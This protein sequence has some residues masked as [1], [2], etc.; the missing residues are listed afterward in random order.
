MRD[1][2]RTNNIL[3]GSIFILLGELCFVTM[4]SLVKLLAETMPSQNIVF[5]RNLFGLLTLA[6]ILINIGFSSLKTRVIHFHLLRSLAGIGAMYCFFYALAKLPLADAMLLKITVPLFIPIIAFL[7]ISEYVSIRTILAI[8]IGFTGVVIILKPT[9]TIQLASFAGLLGGAL[10]A[11]AKVTIR[12]MS[13]TESTSTIVFYFATISLI[14]SF[15]PLLKYWQ[16]PTIYEWWLLI[17][18]GIVGTFGQLFLT[19][20]YT[21]APASRVGPFTYSSIVFA[22]I[23]GWIFWEEK[24]TLLTVSGA[25]LII[26]A[27]VLI[28]H[29]KQLN[30]NPKSTLSETIT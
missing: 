27:G 10:A 23:I 26:F 2:M 25:M 16:N 19:K 13:G 20:A 14:V 6:P 8:T 15:I 12:R 4:G 7:W 21:L 1:H 9:G 28:F 29:E 3:L 30:E 22:S 24:I 11:L 17:L 18:L 5:F